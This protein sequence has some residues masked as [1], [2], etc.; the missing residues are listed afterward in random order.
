MGCK[1]RQ[2]ISYL[3][4]F[5]N[6]EEKLSALHKSDFRIKRSYLLFKHLKILYQ[7]LEVIHIAGTKGKG[8][9]AAFTAYILAASGFR[10][11]LYTSPH[12]NDL[13]ERIKI[14]IRSR[15][16]VI[17][18]LIAKKD[19]IKI[20]N[21]FK[22]HLDKSDCC[23]PTFFEIYTAV[24]LKYFLESNLD[25]VVLETGLG[26]RLDATNVVPPR[27]TIITRISYDHTNILG[28]HL[29]DIAAEKAGIIKSDIPVV[30]AP[31][32]KQALSVILKKCSAVFA[33]NY[34][35]GRDFNFS[36]VRFNHQSTH[37]NFHSQDL[38]LNNLTITL[39]GHHQVENAAIA[40]AA[41]NIL[42][43]QSIKLKNLD[44]KTG[45]RQAKLPGRFEVVTRNPLLIL[46]VAHNPSSFMALA[47][48]LNLYFARRKII[49]IFAVCKD[50]NFKMM[51]KIIPY[52]KIIIT[53]FNNH[54]CLSPDELRRICRLKAP[55]ITK[56]I[57]KAFKIAHS[58]YNR[59]SLIL[60]SGS[61]FLVAEAKKLL[62]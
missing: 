56:D 6:Y 31:Q 25:Y 23:R 41:L 36:N 20:V 37:F 17:T 53:S 30:I 21:K 48:T 35:L 15:S 26:G 38:D 16:K 60:V 46:D 5:L 58:Y 47:Q 61:F 14:V 2:I 45:L 33:Q 55:F 13:R 10:V 27:V 1:Y 18:N 54:R 40:I 39:L 52:D 3:D 7:N 50:K 28:R 49:L 19:L 8:S 32:S 51:L 57:E 24:A 11:G 12:F 22:L 62:N 59:N 4:S 43:N 42:K 44:F 29:E 9:V 34:I